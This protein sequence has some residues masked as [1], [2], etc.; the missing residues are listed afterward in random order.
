MRTNSKSLVAQQRLEQVQLAWFNHHRTQQIK[1]RVFVLEK[2]QRLQ[3]H[4][5]ALKRGLH[6]K[7]FNRFMHWMTDPP[8]GG[9]KQLPFHN[10][11]RRMSFEF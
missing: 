1:M 10:S 8:A 3:R 2:T 7:S 11:R 9:S 6:Q 5:F 4:W